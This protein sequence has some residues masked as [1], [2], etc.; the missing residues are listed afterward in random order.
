MSSSTALVTVLPLLPARFPFVKTQ[1][2]TQAQSPT[3]EETAAE[4]VKVELV[5][6]LSWEVMDCRS[7][8]N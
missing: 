2:L 7:R 8:V 6:L 4:V 3:E 1:L 5:D